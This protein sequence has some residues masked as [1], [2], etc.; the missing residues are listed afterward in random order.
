MKKKLKMYYRVLSTQHPKVASEDHKNLYC[1]STLVQ[2][3]LMN[4]LLKL[5]SMSLV[6]PEE[7]KK[8]RDWRLKRLKIF[9]KSQSWQLLDKLFIAASENNFYEIMANCKTNNAKIFWYFLINLWNWR[10]L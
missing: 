4:D 1:E 10:K 9:H 6:F 3:L 7:T 8:Q 5:I 2:I